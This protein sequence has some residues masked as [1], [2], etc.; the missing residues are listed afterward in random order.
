MS[1]RSQEQKLKLYG[2]YFSFE[3]FLFLSWEGKRRD[4]G[5]RKEEAEEKEILCLDNHKR[6]ITENGEWW[7][8]GRGE[9]NSCWLSPFPFLYQLLSKIDL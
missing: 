1:S 5:E 2:G 4:R 6:R 7:T 8:K 3:I 9:D